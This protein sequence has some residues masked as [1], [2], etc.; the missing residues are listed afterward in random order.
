M[1]RKGLFTEAHENFLI[2]VLVGLIKFN[3]KLLNLSKGWV[4]TLLVRG[5]DNF[6]LEKIRPDWK[7]DL[8]PM[9]DAGM[10]GK[11]E[12]VRSLL[13]DLTNKRVDIK[14]LDDEQE[15]MLF[16]G[17]YRFLFAAIDYAIVKHLT[18]KQAA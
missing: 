1:N 16:D 15:L 4:I 6:L 8:V 11:K 13:I 10:L 3:N 14:Q 2:E 17:L 18:R 7:A 12:E 9:I 5:L